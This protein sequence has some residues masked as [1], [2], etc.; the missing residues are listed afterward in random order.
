MSDLHERTKEHP[1]A[2][3][4]QGVNSSIMSIPRISLLL[5][6]VD[7]K[8]HNIL[9][10]FVSLQQSPLSNIYSQSCRQNE[11]LFFY[12]RSMRAPQSLIKEYCWLRVV[13]NVK[14]LDK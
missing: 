4:I 3:Q 5:Y 8:L 1:S 2:R 7:Q 11:D 9:V 10:I 13:I 12:V 6:K 14:V